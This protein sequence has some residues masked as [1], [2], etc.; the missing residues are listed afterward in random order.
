MVVSQILLHQKNNMDLFDS[1][2]QSEAYG[3][4]AD[5]MR[6]KTIDDIVGQEHLLGQ[7][8]IL[9]TLIEK[10]NLSSMIFWG[11][12]GVGKTTIA[13]VIAQATG[14][15]FIAMSAVSAGVKD[16]RDV[17]KQAE[18]AMKFK[19]KKTILFIDEIH[20]FNKSQQ[21]AL[22][23]HVEK[24]TVTLIGATTE[25]PS[26]EVNSALL[27]RSRVFVLKAHT[28]ESLNTILDRALADSDRGLGE[29]KIELAPDAR[30]YVIEFSNGDGRT[31]LNALELGVNFSAGAASSRKKKGKSP[32]LTRALFEEALQHKAL[33]YDKGGEEHYNIIS[34]FI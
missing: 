30:E 33:Q 15:N 16:L 8:K 32:A 9:R 2:L 11:P 21:D 25:N 22:L 24:G 5:R 18:D 34:A 31:L 1:A 7:G 12:P 29:Q 13:H 17:V 27:S 3:P 10:D 23:P 14:A 4:L 20:R 19:H 6:P 26:F 28:V